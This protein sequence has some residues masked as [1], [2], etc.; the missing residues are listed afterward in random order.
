[1]DT[2]IIAFSSSGAHI[3]RCCLPRDRTS[4]SRRERENEGGDRGHPL[5]RYERQASHRQQ[6]PVAR[7][8]SS[9]SNPM[10]GAVR[11]E[12][13]QGVSTRNLPGSSETSSTGRRSR[14]RI[15]RTILSPSGG[16]SSRMKRIE[17]IKRAQ[18]PSRT[19]GGARVRS[20]AM[21]DAVPSS[22]KRMPNGTTK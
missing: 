1:M 14:R 19:I 12:S 15:S 20:I 10:L 17:P 9:C 18:R 6:I 5:P 22:G 3:R 4:V 8:G 7:D 21:Q 16:V 13:V 2:R 11:R